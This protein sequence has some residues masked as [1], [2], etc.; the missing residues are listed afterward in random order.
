ME[1]ASHTSVCRRHFLFCLQEEPAREGAKMANTIRDAITLDESKFETKDAAEFLAALRAVE[2]NSTWKLH[3]MGD[4]TVTKVSELVECDADAFFEGKRQ[5]PYTLVIRSYSE[6]TGEQE[7][8]EVLLRRSAVSDMFLRADEATTS[9]I[10]RLEDHRDILSRIYSKM[11]KKL[12]LVLIRGNRVA[13]IH[14][15]KYVP[16]AQDAIFEMVKEYLDRSVLG[17]FVYG[18]Y[19]NDYTYSMY[20]LEDVNLVKAYRDS[21]FS[22]G[23]LKADE[24]IKAG[25]R[26]ST[27]DVGKNT[28]R[29]TPYIDRNGAIIQLGRPF[30]VKHIGD[31]SAYMVQDKIDM[32]FKRYTQTVAELCDLMTTAIYHPVGALMNAGQKLRLPMKILSDYVE[33]LESSGR[34][35]EG[36]PITAY[37]CYEILGEVLLKS[38]KKATTERYFALQES[39]YTALSYNWTDMDRTYVMR[40]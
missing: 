40:K 2:N 23:L 27:S 16:I 38:E 19:H 14:S 37:T 36:E 5:S 24:D 20:E 28:V 33:S 18:F 35:K 21:L 7:T 25:L 22:A 12:A 4:I 1:D 26:V 8:K 3:S 31:A 39:L 29:L 34:I 9:G 6:V 32:L 10:K 13:A 30:D 17:N 11:P 15:D